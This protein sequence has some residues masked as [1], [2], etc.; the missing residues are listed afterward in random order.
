MVDALDGIIKKQGNHEYDAL[1]KELK[2]V[3]IKPGQPTTLVPLPSEIFT[4]SP[5]RDLE[6][7]EMMS[8]VLAVVLML[9]LFF[10]PRICLRSRRLSRILAPYLRY[11]CFFVIFT[12]IGIFLYVLTV[13]NIRLSMVFLTLIDMVEAI[14]NITKKVVTDVAVVVGVLLLYAYR[15]RLAILFG[16][17][18][19]QLVRADWRDVAT[20]FSL[21]RFEVIELSIWKVEDLPPS[22][23]IVRTAFC[24]VVNG[25]NEPMNTR[26]ID[27]GRDG[28][29]FT[30]KETF[31]LNYDP[32]DDQTK[33]SLVIRKQE[34][35]SNSIAGNVAPI[36]GALTGAIAS[37]VLPFGMSAGAIAGGAAAAGAA[38]SLCEEIARLDLSSTMINRFLESTRGEMLPSTQHSMTTSARDWGTR[39]QFHVSHL[40]PQGRIWFRFRSLTSAE[41]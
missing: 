33:M 20:C 17:E 9:S 8:A 30:L 31:Q 13:T 2:K 32:E 35:L 39:D 12:S 24:Q 1:L 4:P 25:Y 38:S 11:Y 26:P 15:A 28:T 29:S 10:L 5:L 19:Q 22:W 18:G 7:V 41:V 14:L 6:D 21:S 16:L 23:G 34:I 27:I 40:I 3:K 37:V 36:S